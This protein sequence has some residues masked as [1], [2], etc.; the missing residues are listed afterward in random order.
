MNPI[1]D[2]WRRVHEFSKGWLWARNDNSYDGDR[3]YMHQLLKRG[4]EFNAWPTLSAAEQDAVLYDLKLERD[5]LKAIAARRAPGIARAQRKYEHAYR[6]RNK[7]PY[8]A[9]RK[10]FKWQTECLRWIKRGARKHFD[11]IALPVIK[12]PFPKLDLA[13]LVAVQPMMRPRDT[14]DAMEYAMRAVRAAADRG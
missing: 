10:W 5:A 7:H 9:S 14:V 6:E 1:T 2:G 11:E 12:A 8:R 13:E 4:I 3:V